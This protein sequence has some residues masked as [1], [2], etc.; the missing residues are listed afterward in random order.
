[1]V[2]QNV[3]DSKTSKMSVF[4]PKYHKRHDLYSDKKARKGPVVSYDPKVWNVSQDTPKIE[5][6]QPSWLATALVNLGYHFGTLSE[7]NRSSPDN[8][9]ART[10]TIR[11]LVQM[12]K[13]KQIP[14]KFLTDRDTIMRLNF[15]HVLRGA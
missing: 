8:N 2:R 1:M 13:H 14:G 10:N 6:L 5:H 3:A 11:T 7:E 4:G 9:T 12:Y 15:R